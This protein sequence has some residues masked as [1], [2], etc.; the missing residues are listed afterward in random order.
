MQRNGLLANRP[1]V[2]AVILLNDKN[3]IVHTETL[4]S[5]HTIRSASYA[6]AL[7]TLAA[8]HV[9]Y[10]LVLMHNHANG[11]MKPSDE[12]LYLTEQLYDILQ[13][14]NITILE[15]LIVHKFDCLPILDQALRRRVSGFP[16]ALT[17]EEVTFLLE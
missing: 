13:E 11:I 16:V 6:K 5:S 10:R 8:K 4:S 1:R 9:A 12:D 3:Q 2:V 14:K 7:E 15:H 17:P